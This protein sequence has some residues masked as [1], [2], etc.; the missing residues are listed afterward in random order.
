MRKDASIHLL[1]HDGAPPNATIYP[2]KVRYSGCIQRT[3]WKEL[4]VIE[5]N[6]DCFK[7]RFGDWVWPVGIGDTKYLTQIELPN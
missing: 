2:V 7:N 3:T 1:M 6:R 4:F 5:Q